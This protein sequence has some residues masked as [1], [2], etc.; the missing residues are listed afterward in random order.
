MDNYPEDSDA[1][2]WEEEQ[3][4]LSKNNRDEVITE[5]QVPTCTSPKKK[6]HVK[7]RSAYKHIPHREKPA[8]LVERRNARE[9]RRVEAVNSAFLRLSRAVPKADRGLG[10][11]KRVSKVRVLQGAIDYIRGM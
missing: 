10:D 4:T 11:S 3:K 5:S 7:K 6:K 2:F 1:I 9:R 8:H